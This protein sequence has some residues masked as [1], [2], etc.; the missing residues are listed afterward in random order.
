MSRKFKI[1]E[2]CITPACRKGR[3]KTEAF[4]E[5]S[6]RLRDAYNDAVKGYAEQNENLTLNLILEVELQEPNKTEGQSER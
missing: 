2:C 1:R 5:A 4:E 3:G 6:R